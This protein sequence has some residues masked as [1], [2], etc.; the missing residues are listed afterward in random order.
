MAHFSLAPDGTLAYIPAGQ[1]A[2]DPLVWVDRDGE[3]KIVSA[4]M[5]SFAGWS[6]ISP[7]ETRLALEGFGEEGT[8]IWIY[9]IGRGTKT[10]LS[11]DGRGIDPVWS[12]DG[13]AV[14]FSLS[15][16]DASIYKARSDGG[17]EPEAVVTSDGARL[18][19]TSWS[20]DGKLLTLDALHTGDVWVASLD[21]G[22]PAPFVDTPFDEWGARFSPDGRFIAYVPTSPGGTRSTSS[23]IPAPA[24]GGPSRPAEDKSLYGPKTEASSSIGTGPSSWSSLFEPSPNS[25]QERRKSS[26]KGSFQ[27]SSSGTYYDVSRDGQ[28]LRHAFTR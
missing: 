24:T 13:D 15:G 17:G 3:S 20:T 10:R 23:P 4:T 11:M 25:E 27:R 12:P 16:G 9:D 22:E 26:S 18:R 5:G 6:R 28:R 8:D 1:S 7:D 2:T 19:V 21:G 14:V